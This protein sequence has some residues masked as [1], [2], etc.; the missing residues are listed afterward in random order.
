[1]VK[2]RRIDRKKAAHHLMRDA[3]ERIMPVRIPDTEHITSAWRE[4]TAR[5]GK[6][7]GL[8]R[9]E[10]QAELAD[11]GVEARIGKRKRCGVG[12]LEG[13]RLARPKFGARQI[14]H[15]RIEIGR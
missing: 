10:H 11:D 13:D 4:G 9:K 6:G 15:R 3:A 1:M 14:E 2:L 8:V 7:G 12:R 5:F